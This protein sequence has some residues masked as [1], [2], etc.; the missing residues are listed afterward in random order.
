MFV[1]VA[2]MLSQIGMSGQ[3]NKIGKP[4]CV[5]SFGNLTGISKDSVKCQPF[6]LVQFFFVEPFFISF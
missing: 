4:G 3:Q 6:N 5:Y 2:I 1:S